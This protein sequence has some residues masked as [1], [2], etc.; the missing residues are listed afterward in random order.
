MNVKLENIS[1][2][3]LSPVAL[4]IYAQGFKQTKRKVPFWRD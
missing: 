2:L 3:F 1:Y 4:R